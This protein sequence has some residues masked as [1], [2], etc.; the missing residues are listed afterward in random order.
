MVGH[1]EWR[2]EVP[3]S[4]LVGKIAVMMEVPLESL[5]LRGI[6]HVGRDRAMYLCREVGQQGLRKIGEIFGVKSAAVSKQWQSRLG[7]GLFLGLL[8]TALPACDS[9]KGPGATSTTSAPLPGAHQAPTHSDQFV[10]VL[11]LGDKMDNRV[12]ASP[13]TQFSPSTHEIFGLTNALEDIAG[14]L[15]TALIRVMHEDLGHTPQRLGELGAPGSIED[16]ELG[17][18]ELFVPHESRIGQ[19]DR[20]QCG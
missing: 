4:E 6:N 8:V 1:S 10:A 3:L 18:A 11:T 17:H 20:I 12:I 19:R 5:L 14:L 16:M 2:R 9:S 13:T 7:T 15:Q